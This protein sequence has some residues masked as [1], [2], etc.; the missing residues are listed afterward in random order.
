M[1]NLRK[2]AVLLLAQ[3]F[4]VGA[5]MAQT[6]GTPAE[7]KSSYVMAIPGFEGFVGVGIYK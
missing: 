3:V 7:A 6:H 5:A 4:L 1:L 2:F